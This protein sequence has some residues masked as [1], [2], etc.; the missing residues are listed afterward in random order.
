MDTSVS[1][2]RNKD[3]SLLFRLGFG[4]IINTSPLLRLFNACVAVAELLN[5]QQV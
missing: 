5:G 4:C 3:D 2:V 1:R